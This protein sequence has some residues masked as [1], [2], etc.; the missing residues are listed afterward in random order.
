MDENKKRWKKESEQLKK[1]L[2]NR[3]KVVKKNPVTIKFG[4]TKKESLNQKNN[5]SNPKD[6]Q[7]LRQQLGL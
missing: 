4:G 5:K 6:D 7:S 2:D 3:E 1:D